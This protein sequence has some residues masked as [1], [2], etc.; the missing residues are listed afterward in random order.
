MLRPTDLDAPPALHIERL[1]FSY[2]DGHP[3]LHEVTLD[4]RQG[5]KVAIVGPNGAGKSTLI[6][7][8]NG[9][10]TGQ[11]TVRVCGLDVVKQNLGRVRALVGMVFQLPDDQLFSP[12]VFDDVAFGPLY[13]GLPEAEVRARVAQAT[14][15]ATG[16]SIRV[17]RTRSTPATV[18]FSQEM[19]EVWLEPGMV[20]AVA[21]YRK[22][23]K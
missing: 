19:V 16:A 23:T 11:G 10:L 2:P 6:L 3:A 1:S 20:I 5:E 22:A 17:G 13:Q 18:A 21:K 9:I 15:S 4:V 12:T 7:H 8:L 14:P